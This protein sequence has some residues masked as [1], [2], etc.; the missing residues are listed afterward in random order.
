MLIATEH[1]PPDQRGFYGSLVQLGFPLGMSLGTA[2]FFDEGFGKP[3]A[4]LYP[5]SALQ[6]A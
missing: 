5:S 3:P 6:R 1:S 2:S 4:R